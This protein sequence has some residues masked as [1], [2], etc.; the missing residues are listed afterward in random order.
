MVDLHRRHC[1]GTSSFR[2]VVVASASCA[3]P[4][5]TAARGLKRSGPPSWPS[6][7]LGDSGG[8]MPPT[9]NDLSVANAWSPVALLWI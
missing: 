1:S 9:S 6:V 8:E 7:K 4:S 5:L 3:E 2:S